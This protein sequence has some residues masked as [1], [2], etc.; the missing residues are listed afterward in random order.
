MKYILDTVDL[1]DVEKCNEFFPI[2]GV[3]SNPSIVRQ[4]GV[5][6]FYGHFQ[7]LRSVIGQE[8][9]LHIQ[10]IGEDYD[11][12][13]NDAHAILEKIDRSV[14]IKIPV[15]MQGL[16]A[17]MALKKENVHITA[18]AI[19]QKA[20]ALLAME[21]GADYVAPYYNRMV[22]MDIDA[23]QV[24]EGIANMIS[25]YGYGMQI[26]AA[27]F[28]N[29]AQVNHA[30]M[31]GAHAVTLQPQLLYDIFAMPAIAKAVDAFGKDWKK[32]FGS[33]TPADL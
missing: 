24:I 23:D 20:Q 9:S 33:K 19:Y 6:D 28:K 27:S 12:I 4:C 5:T 26:L 32:T 7:T 30:F 25:K 2:A 14:Y 21:A 3:T 29:M 16:K 15:T 11:A 17:I 18:T 22:A 13:M 1:A 10:V 31:M 8:K